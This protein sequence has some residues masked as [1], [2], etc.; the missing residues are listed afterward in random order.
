MKPRTLSHHIG[1]TESQPDLEGVAGRFVM[2]FVM[3]F[4]TRFVTRQIHTAPGVGLIV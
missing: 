1:T 3:R 2:R 4:V